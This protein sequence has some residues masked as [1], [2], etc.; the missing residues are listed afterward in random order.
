MT[1]V[2]LVCPTEDD[3]KALALVLASS[4]AQAH[5]V[6]ELHGD[7]GAGKTT[8]VRHWLHALGVQGRIKSPTYALLEPHQAPPADHWPHG[9]DISHLDLYRFEDPR[10]LEE[11]GLREL[12]SAPGLK[13]VEW[14]QH[15]G[16]QRPLADVVIAMVPLSEVSRHITLTA[17]T[18]TGHQFLQVL[19]T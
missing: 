12:L 19:H 14:A 11:S 4:P 17:H 2:T 6:V 15:A 8:L 7:L 9:L 10:E 18:P 13:L 5:I 3:T 1:E 16:P